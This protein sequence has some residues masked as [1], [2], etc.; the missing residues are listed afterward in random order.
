MPDHPLTVGDVEQHAATVS[1]MA[2]ALLSGLASG[3]YDKEVAFTEDMLSEL[4][5]VFPLAGAVEKALQVFLVINNMTAPR[6]PVVPDGR[7]G[8]VPASNSRYNPKTGE[9]I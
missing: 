2:A 8:Y 5:L 4:G 6:G 7:G 3:K 1:A 9:F